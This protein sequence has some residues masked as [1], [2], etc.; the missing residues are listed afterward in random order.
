MCLC[1]FLACLFM[2]FACLSVFLARFCASFARHHV[3]LRVL[4]RCRCLCP[5][6]CDT[7]ASSMG[8]HAF[9]IRIFSCFRISRTSSRALHAF[10]YPRFTHRVGMSHNDDDSS[11]A[12]QRAHMQESQLV[13]RN[14]ISNFCR[15]QAIFTPE[16]VPPVEDSDYDVPK[17][18]ALHLPSEPISSR[19]LSPTGKI[20]ANTEAKLRFA[21]ATDASSGLCRSLAIRA[22]LSK[23]K[24]TQVG[25][26]R[27][28]THACALLST[29]EEKTVTYAA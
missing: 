8:L 11:T 21:Q 12:I 15:T 9:L 13:L 20:L 29:A 19:M 27:A 2:F 10:V 22:E 3:S 5:I 24:D 4:A 1:V 14:R 18:H 17:S 7:H 6:L 25:G 26:R 28:S 23:Y 16:A